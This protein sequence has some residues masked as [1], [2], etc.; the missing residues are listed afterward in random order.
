R[1]QLW[2]HAFVFM[3]EKDEGVFPLLILHAFQPFT[4]IVFVIGGATQAQVPPARR[5]D[6]FSEW[7]L[8]SIG[9]YQ[10]AIAGP[11]QIK[12]LIVEPALVA[13]LECRTQ[14]RLQQIE[15]SLQPLN[16]F[17]KVWRKLKENDPES[18]LKQRRSLQQILC[19]IRDIVEALDVGDALSGFNREAKA[20]R[21]LRLPILDHAR[22]R[23]AI[24]SVVDFH[25]RQTPRVIRKHFF[26][27]QVLGIKTSLPF[28]IAVAAGADVEF[29]RT[30][31]EIARAIRNAAPAARLP[32]SAVCK[33][34]RMGRV[35]VKRPLMNPKTI[36]ASTVRPTEINSAVATPMRC[37]YAAAM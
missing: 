24:E 13:K 16:V 3:L 11:Q 18:L 2:P 28:F 5:A 33:A 14:V 10:R 25:R 26:R 27:G 7:F 30:P 23:Q 4:E 36:N 34:L 22:L 12:S 20:L 6:D 21:H 32:I 17:L 37:K 1:R 31:H 15:K 19:F 8:V 35:P 9:N 29:H